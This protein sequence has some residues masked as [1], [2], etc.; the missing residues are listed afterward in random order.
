MASVVISYLVRPLFIIKKFLLKTR[1]LSN[2]V[3]PYDM[4]QYVPSHLGLQYLL[5]S[6]CEKATRHKHIEE[7]L[8]QL[9]KHT[10]KDRTA[11]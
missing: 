9:K 7:H 5:L 10:H 4:T 3:P 11:H 6:F 2:N 8:V 1:S